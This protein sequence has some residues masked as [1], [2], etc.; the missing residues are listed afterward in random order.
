M[1]TFNNLLDTLFWSIV[2]LFLNF[3]KIHPQLR[4]WYPV[5]KHTNR[6]TP[7]KT[8]PRQK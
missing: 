8:E 3:I 4:E 1:L 5:S 2:Y 7:V 6:Q